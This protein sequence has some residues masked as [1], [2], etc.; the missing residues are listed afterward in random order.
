MA[1]G[2]T[3]ILTLSQTE[4]TLAK[5]PGK[6]EAPSQ[7]HRDH[8]DTTSAQ[9]LLTDD[10]MTHSD[11]DEENKKTS[12]EIVDLNGANQIENITLND[13]LHEVKSK[14]YDQSSQKLDESVSY[15]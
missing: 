12:K 1:S 3:G 13:L 10:L 4:G 9:I 5:Q 11:T 6:N 15:K 8:R 2:L 7:I 14:N